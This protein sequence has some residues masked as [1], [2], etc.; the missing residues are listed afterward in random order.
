MS[1]NFPYYRWFPKDYIGDAEVQA[2]TDDQDLAYRR[3]LDKSW[4]I[5]PL[6][7]DVKKLAAY[8]R[9]TLVRFEQCWCFPLSDCWH[10]NKDGKLINNRLE[11]ERDFAFTRAN[12]A[13][14]AVMSRWKKRR[15]RLKT[16]KDKKGY[17]RNTPVIPEP[18]GSDTIKVPVPVPVPLPKEEKK[19]TP[20][21][22]NVEKKERKMPIK[23]DWDPKAGE[24]GEGSF[25][26]QRELLRAKLLGRYE[27][28]FGVAWI[29]ATWNSCIEWCQDHP[30][31]IAEKK[32]YYLFV[33]G[34]FRRDANKDAKAKRERT[35]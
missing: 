13:R 32:D 28:E 30:E 21:S 11:D 20:S 9:Y 6:P 19:K 27:K 3:L 23:I 26:G 1:C 8:V 35:K 25:V 14:K 22:A 34:W 33:L 4:E 18:Y 12:N 16:Q 31:E 24:K 29:G 5:G 15:K 2:M 10:E 7:N 17:A